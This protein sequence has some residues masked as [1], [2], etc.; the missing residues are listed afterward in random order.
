MNLEK[1]KKIILLTSETTNQDHIPKEC[2][3]I[4]GSICLVEF[5]PE[6]DVL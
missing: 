6:E 5:Q 1:Y 3:L 2:I 4:K